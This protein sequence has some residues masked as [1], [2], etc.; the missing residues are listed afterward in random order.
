[1]SFT[2]KIFNKDKPFAHVLFFQLSDTSR[3][4][5]QDFIDLCIKYLSN[6]P[7]QQCFSIGYRVLDL[8][9][10][11]NGNSYDVSVNITFDNTVAFENYLASQNHEV[12][13]TESAGM[14]LGRIAHNSYVQAIIESPTK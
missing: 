8:D 14:F 11:A 7:G 9:G 12:F 2:T 5:Q 3:E 6:R 1:M 10:D 13:I 4:L